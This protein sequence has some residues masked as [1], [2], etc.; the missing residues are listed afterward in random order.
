MKKKDHYTKLFPLLG[1]SFSFFAKKPQDYLTSQ[2]NEK[3]IFIE[4]KLENIVPSENYIDEK[5]NSKAQNFIKSLNHT[6]VFLLVTDPIE[7]KLDQKILLLLHTEDRLNSEQ[8]LINNRHTKLLFSYRDDQSKQSLRLSRD[9]LVKQSL[10]PN[11][12]PG[13]SKIF[14][15]GKSYY[16]NNIGGYKSIC[17]VFFD[18]HTAEDFLL[19]NSRDA[20]NLSKSLPFN[21]NQEVLKG[22]L[23]SKIISVG[24][25][26]FVSYYSSPSNETF[27]NKIEFLFFPSIEE[28]LPLSKSNSK[29]QSNQFS[30]KSFKFYQDQYFLKLASNK[31]P[32]EQM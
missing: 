29:K 17:P 11:R 26:D 22:V 15:G 8:S 30:T 25:G 6:E 5:I 19:E 16:K 32:S 2:V 18:K 27:L 12:F 21:T 10:R 31:I 3:E 24:L 20:L 28:V 4:A 1:A 7:K 14:R 9:D 13:L 23:K